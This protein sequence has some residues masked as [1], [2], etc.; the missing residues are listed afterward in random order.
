MRPT[1]LQN[2]LR[3]Y[4]PAEKIRWQVPAV[5]RIKLSGSQNQRICW[6]QSPGYIPNSTTR[7]HQP[8]PLCKCPQFHTG[9]RPFPAGAPLCKRDKSAFDVPE[10][11]SQALLHRTLPA[12]SERWYP[13]P[14]KSCDTIALH[15]PGRDRLPD[16]RESSKP[17]RLWQIPLEKSPCRT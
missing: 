17:W 2:L 4:F 7:C 3:Y 16:S 11:H 5:P 9:P 6:A 13:P 12:R 14:A 15:P 1:P 10:T 8:A